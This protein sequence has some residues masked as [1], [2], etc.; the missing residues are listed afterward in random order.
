MRINRLTTYFLIILFYTTVSSNVIANGI[1]PHEIATL[2]YGKLAMTG[3]H[4]KAVRHCEQPFMETWQSSTTNI[5]H[6]DIGMPIVEAPNDTDHLNSQ[7]VIDEGQFKQELVAT[8]PISPAYTEYVS[9]GILSSNDA[10]SLNSPSI[11]VNSD[12][13]TLDQK[14]HIINFE[15]KVILWFNDMVLKTDTIEVIYKQ[16]ANGRE[17]DKIII[18]NKLLA[19]RILEQDILIADCAEYLM[20]SNKL[21]LTGNVKLQH[22]DNVINTQKLIY[23]TKLRKYSKNS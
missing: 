7:K 2:S 18:P 12:Y 17:I 14:K 22:E 9:N 13:L 8:N 20:N 10:N 23:H 6:H 19:I 1:I 16:L 4:H 11:Y 21:I 15:G 3:S 5:M